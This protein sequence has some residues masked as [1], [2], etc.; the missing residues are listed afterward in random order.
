M[1]TMSTPQNLSSAAESL[2]NARSVAQMDRQAFA[3]RLGIGTLSLMAYETG[4]VDTP[5][6]LADAAWKVADAVTRGEDNYPA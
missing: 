1:M 6:A 3:E 4:L 2:I 5:Q